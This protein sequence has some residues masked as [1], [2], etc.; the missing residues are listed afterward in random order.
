M[1][2]V[3]VLIFMAMCIFI[4]M[5]L[6]YL[7]TKT[8]IEKEVIKYIYIEKQTP[9]GIDQTIAVVP[10]VDPKLLDDCT[11]CLIS[12]GLKKSEANKKVKELFNKKQYLSIEEFLMDAYKIS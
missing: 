2:Q 10:K 4:P 1:D 6:P 12:L 8:S 3:A 5:L 9:K 11:Q 7:D